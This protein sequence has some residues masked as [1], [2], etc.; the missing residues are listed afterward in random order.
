M[1]FDALFIA[2]GIHRDE[3]V[4]GDAIDEAVLAERLAPFADTVVAT[5]VR[6]A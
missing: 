6:L 5:M 3:I 2:G 1:G 4:P